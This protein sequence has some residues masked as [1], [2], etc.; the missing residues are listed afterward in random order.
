MSSISLEGRG[1]KTKLANDKVGEQR[2]LTTKTILELKRDLDTL[3]QCIEGKRKRALAL[4]L[5]HID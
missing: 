3:L 2:E 5:V 4:C 1:A